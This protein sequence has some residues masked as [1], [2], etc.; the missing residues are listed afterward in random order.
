MSVLT[1]WIC[2]GE[3]ARTTADGTPALH[4]RSEWGGESSGG[5]RE[6]RLEL[7][8]AC[9]QEDDFELALLALG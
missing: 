2:A 6:L 3:D 7:G 9:R 8:F 5:R 1:R 4:L